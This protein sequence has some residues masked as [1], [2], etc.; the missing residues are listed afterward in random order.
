MTFKI[1]VIRSD[2]VNDDFWYFSLSLRRYLYVYG[3]MKSIK[4]KIGK[5]SNNLLYR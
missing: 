4:E 1:V 2:L 3:Y 5:G